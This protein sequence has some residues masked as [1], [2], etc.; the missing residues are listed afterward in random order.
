[1]RASGQSSS[2][3]GF[4]PFEGTERWLRAGGCARVCG[5]PSLASTRSRVLKAT[6]NPARCRV[7]ASFLG[8]DP[9]EGTESPTRAASSSSLST[10]LGFDPFE[11]TERFLAVQAAPCAGVLPWLRPVRGY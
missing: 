2:F 7:Y 6:T 1:M 11:G 10:F 4:D 5:Y 9:F 3:L 8:F